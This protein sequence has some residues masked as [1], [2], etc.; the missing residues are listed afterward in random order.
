MKP[1]IVIVAADPLTFN[2]FLRAITKKLS[3]WA[4][5]Y[6]LVNIHKDIF[7]HPD[8]K[9]NVKIVP[10]PIKRKISPL[11]DFL[12]FLILLKEISAIRPQCVISATPKAGFLSQFCSFLLIIKTRIHIFT[13]QV[14]V[15]K[16]GRL[17]FI[18]KSIDKLIANF[19]TI[20][21]VDGSAQQK[22]LVDEKVL[23]YR[24]SKVTGYGSVSGVDL[25]KFKFNNKFRSEIRSKYNLKES[26]KV[27]LYLGRIDVDKGIIDLLEAFE[28]Y[29]LPIHKD[30][31]L[32]IIGYP[33]DHA[34]ISHLLSS[35]EILGS[36]LQISGPTLNPE[37][38]LSFAD[39]FCLPSYRE[40]LNVTLLEAAAC[41]LSSVCS[42]I[43]GTNDALIDEISGLKFQPKDIKEL[44]NQIIRIIEDEKLA[45]R[46]KVNALE[47]VQKYFDSNIVTDLFDKFIFQ[48]LEKKIYK[49]D[50]SL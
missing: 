33:E 6:V 31:Y 40:G 23:S 24:K 41:E 13:G 29:I 37:K 36:H 44:A 32:F 2:T 35:K 27:I 42:D 48:D 12:A 18:L 17:K 47:R 21:L 1:K 20:N 15:N 11:R 10:I 19:T 14:W 34:L 38:Y 3:K 39:V 25:K 46:L 49:K 28:N 5:I 8:V 22:F 16:K 4:D 45:K 9:N 43:Y 26:S 7:L 50:I 30:S